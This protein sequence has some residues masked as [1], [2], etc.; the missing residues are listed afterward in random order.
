VLTAPRRWIVLALMTVAYVFAATARGDDYERWYVVELGGQRAGWAM[1]SR[2]TE[3]ERITTRS[4][5]HLSIKRGTAEVS[6]ATDASFVETEDHRP[7]SIR[8]EQKLGATPTVLEG[9]Y[10]ADGVHVVDSSNG[11]P[12]KRVLPVPDGEWLT[13]A[14]ADEYVAQR[15][16]AMPERI[17]V[18]TLELG[19][20]LDVQSALKPAVITRTRLERT[21]I[22][23]GEREATGV[24]C[25]TTSSTQPQIESK[26]VLDAQGIPIRSETSLGPVVAVM[27]AAEKS[28]ALA[29]GEAPEL[30]L[31]TF[32]TPD[33]PIDAARASTRAVLVVSV[34][35]GALPE[36]PETGAQSVERMS[37]RAAR[38]TIDASRHAPAPAE[39]AGSADFSRPSATITS[40]DERVEA[41]AV[42]GD[43]T[44]ENAE[45]ARRAVHAFINRKNLDVGFAT[46][47]E[48]ARTRT[49]DCTE[50]AVLLAAV[51]RAMHIPSR[52]ASGLVYADEFEG[53]EGIFAYHMWT[54]ALLDLGHGPTWVDLDATLPDA[55]P[56]DATHIALVVSAL[57]DGQTDRVFT[58][59]VSAI[60]RLKI[61]VESVTP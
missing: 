23:A 4:Q 33:R 46:A 41:L 48:V 10:E 19:G 12:R 31:R 44:P 51:L 1:S 7:V 2:T 54:Q 60:G 47:A 25:I 43:A 36:I 5:L 42:A 32:I 29:E 28:I 8:V 61:K 6:I 34:D 45:K 30:M 24:Q 15:L 16:A 21:T 53:Q 11:S 40:D 9:T 52:V 37:A 39:D 27:T 26:E 18:R 55:V 58:S 20:G 17:V 14:A 13:P 57:A 50:H 56:F 49:G 59:L 35:G 3:A 22:K 38:L